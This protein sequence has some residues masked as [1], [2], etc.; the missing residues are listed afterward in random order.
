[1]WFNKKSTGNAQAIYKLEMQLN[2][3]KADVERIKSD[4]RRELLEYAELGEKMRRLYLR[5]A[6]RAKVEEGQ[7][8]PPEGTDNNDQEALSA[9]ETR[10][11]I[12]SQH[13]IG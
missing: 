10:E 12:E 9:R 2:S 3:L 13:R 7:T 11:L 8:S 5:I 6:R 1:M 4:N